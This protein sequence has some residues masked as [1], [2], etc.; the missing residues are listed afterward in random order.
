MFGAPDRG[1]TNALSLPP[2][3]HANECEGYQSSSYLRMQ[4]LA[5]RRLEA[6]LL[7]EDMSG[8]LRDAIAAIVMD[9]MVLVLGI[10]LL[11]N[12]V[13]ARLKHGSASGSAAPAISH[14]G[15]PIVVEKNLYALPT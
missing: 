4:L 6:P 10:N 15:I 3:T 8:L 2:S 11:K 1:D 12:E 5:C 7:R 9:A 13:E 14:L